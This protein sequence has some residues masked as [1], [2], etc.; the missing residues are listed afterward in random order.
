M[1]NQLDLKRT[2]DGVS[3]RGEIDL[4]VAGLF[5]DGLQTAAMDAT[6]GKLVIDMSG[7]TFMDS[8]GINGLLKVIHRCPDID[9][10]IIPSYRVRA[11]FRVAGLLDR[12]WPNVEVRLPPDDDPAA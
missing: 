7:V 1:P 8:T 12:T 6:P 5:A 3:V 10:V 4:N 9:L 11:I 2:P